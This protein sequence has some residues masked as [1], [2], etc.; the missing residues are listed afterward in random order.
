MR[1]INH[2]YI[3]LFEYLSLNN[4][5]LFRW[6]HNHVDWYDY[7]GMTENKDL[8]SYGKYSDNHQM[9]WLTQW[10]GGLQH[11][12]SIV[13]DLEHT[14][15]PF[16]DK[17]DLLKE[18]LQPYRGIK[19]IL[20]GITN[21]V[22]AP[23]LFLFD[24][25]AYPTRSL[26]TWSFE[27]LGR[28]LNHSLMCL[29]TWSA[30]GLLSLARGVVQLATTP[31]N[32]FLRLPL[33]G[34]LTGIQGA[35][36]IIENDQVGPLIHEVE[37]LL[38]EDCEKV[39]KDMEYILLE[40]KEA[41]LSWNAAKFGSH[42]NTNTNQEICSEYNKLYENNDEKILNPGKVRWFLTKIKPKVDSPQDNFQR[43]YGSTMGGN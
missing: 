32:W 23:L 26:F 19:N 42:N 38:H 18:I 13:N 11:L 21:L 35:P 31:L 12:V 4:Y 43:L 41:Y 22:L 3:S 28:N 24:F 10:K 15:K 36:D 25:I 20:R 40:L 7:F 39:T 8:H 2:R 6:I 34:I 9:N 30:D 29:V 1:K 14:V 37:E 27:G 33:R 17:N 16:N 5:P